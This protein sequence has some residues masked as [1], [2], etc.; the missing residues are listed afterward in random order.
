R[1]VRARRRR[2]R[3]PFL[4][5]GSRTE[6]PAPGASA[7]VAASPDQL[8]A[9]GHLP[10]HHAAPSG[11][12]TRCLSVEDRRDLLAV[13]DDG[14]DTADGYCACLRFQ[15]AWTPPAPR[16]TRRPLKH[17]TSLP[18]LGA[19]GF[20]PGVEVRSRTESSGRLSY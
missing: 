5:S 10:S 14:R 13:F 7:P 17:A 16:A 15:P 6:A 4:G 18:S 11:G 2:R 19:L 12:A 8:C 3:R 20:P 9:C 1:R